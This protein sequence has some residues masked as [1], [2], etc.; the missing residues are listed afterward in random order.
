MASPSAEA[1]ESIF[2]SSV[3]NAA[4]EEIPVEEL[5]KCDAIGVYFS[6]HW[7][8]PCRGF[9]PMLIGTYKKLKDSDKRFEVIFVSLDRSEAD[10]KTYFAGMPWTSVR[11]MDSARR[12]QLNNRFTPSGIPALYIVDNEGVMLQENGRQAVVADPEGKNFPWVAFKLSFAER[13]S[14]QL[15]PRLMQLLPLLFILYSLV[16]FVARYLGYL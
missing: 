1:L 3:I 4:G 7:C 13:V 14:S 10:F 5:A 2:G 11:F 15:M 9:T 16:R 12:D 6:A 8:P